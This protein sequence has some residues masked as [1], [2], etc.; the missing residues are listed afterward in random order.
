MKK[1]YKINYT[2]IIYYLLILAIVVPVK[3]PWLYVFTVTLKIVMLAANTFVGSMLMSIHKHKIT[4]NNFFIQN[5][6]FFVSDFSQ[7]T[8]CYFEHTMIQKVR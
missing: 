5:P 8:E 4:L 6:S 3:L 7:I 2:L 1:K